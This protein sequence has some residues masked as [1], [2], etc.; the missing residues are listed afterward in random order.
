MGLA[1]LSF[2]VPRSGEAGG[3]IVIGSGRQTGGVCLDHS[4]YDCSDEAE[5]HECSEHV[6]SHRKFHR[7]LLV[8]TSDIE[9]DRACSAPGT[10]VSLGGSARGCIKLT[11]Q[12]CCMPSENHLATHHP[13]TRCGRA[14]ERFALNPGE[15]HSCCSAAA[16]VEKNSSSVAE[17]IPG[18]RQRPWNT[19]F[20]LSRN[21]C[22][23]SA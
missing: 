6:Q 21:A 19:G 3:T 12:N 8:G 11:E 13:P 1:P 22:R 4:E 18:V 15:S 23:P 14:E 20:L 16:A 10:G 9:R 17:Q 2:A 5:R 7:C